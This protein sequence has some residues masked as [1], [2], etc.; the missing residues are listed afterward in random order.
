MI[1]NTALCFYAVTMTA[2]LDKFVSSFSEIWVSEKTDSIDFQV[3][4]ALQRVCSVNWAST[5]ALRMRADRDDVFILVLLNGHV[6]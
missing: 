4:S 2:A 6:A 3:S 5:D 1:N